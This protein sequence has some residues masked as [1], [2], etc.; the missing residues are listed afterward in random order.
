M[1]NP[2]WPATLPVPTNDQG[3]YAPLVNNVITSNMGSGAPKRRRR[4]TYVPETYTGQLL[5]TSA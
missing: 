5:L 2:L 1:S 3:T 4:F